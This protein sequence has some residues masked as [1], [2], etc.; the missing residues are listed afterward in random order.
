MP[1]VL[2]PH[3][4]KMLAVDSLATCDYH[5]GHA[6]GAG[7]QS[8]HTNLSSSMQIATK[9]GLHLRRRGHAAEN[10]SG[11]WER[12]FLAVVIFELIWMADVRLRRAVGDALTAKPSPW[13]FIHI[14][15]LFI[16]NHVL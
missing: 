2:K 11:R 16:L 4:Q 8:G 1:Q 6:L 5:M 3:P 13:R 15:F 14:S 7:H 10:A 9:F 12:F